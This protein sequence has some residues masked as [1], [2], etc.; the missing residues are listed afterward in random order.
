LELW[1]LPNLAHAWP[2]GN[3][4]APPGRFVAPAPIDAT[5]A[6]ARFLGLD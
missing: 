6:I 3:R 4:F 5:A 1:S 2:I